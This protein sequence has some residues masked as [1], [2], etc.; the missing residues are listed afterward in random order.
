MRMRKHGCAIRSVRR[1]GLSGAIPERAIP[2]YFGNYEIVAQTKNFILTCDDDPEAR[3]RAQ[4]VAGVCEADLARLNDLFSTNFE[5]GNTSDHGIWVH[6]LKD[7]PSSGANGWNYGYEKDQSSRIYLQRAFVPAPPP[8]PPPD[9]PAV[10]PPN[11]NN[12]VIEFPRFVFVAELAEI[13]MDFTG[14]G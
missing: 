1:L 3:L 10:T 7:L 12:A 14:Y 11:L 2:S 4:N 8:P 6:A 9:P 5:A 13:L